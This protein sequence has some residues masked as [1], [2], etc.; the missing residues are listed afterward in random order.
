MEQYHGNLPDDPVT[1]SKL[2]GIGAY[3]CGAIASIAFNLDMPVL[4]GNLKR[5]LSRVFNVEKPANLPEGE[6]A[7][8]RLAGE[9]L[10]KGHAGDFNQAMMDLGATICL[11]RNPICS[12]CPLM[13]VCESNIK[14]LQDQR[15]VM[16]PKARIPHITVTAAILQR[17]GKVLLAKRPSRGLLGG[18]WEFPGGKKEDGESLEDCLV[19]EIREELGIEVLAG[20]TFGI[21][22]HA[23]THF[24]ITLHAYLCTFTKGEPSPVEAEA[25]AWVSPEELG[26]YPM[27]KVDRCISRRLQGVEE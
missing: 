12:L 13:L 10:P 2:P 11:P 22:K 19:R 14:G 15:P 5:V 23:Y 21:Y 6:A 20:A 17:D 16:K 3:T 25:L 4:D 26:D 18:M 9:N 1:L 24:R 27:G 7:L 8:Q